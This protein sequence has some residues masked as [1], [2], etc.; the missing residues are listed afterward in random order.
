ML[1]RQRRARARVVGWVA[2]PAA[3]LS[4]SG[5]RAAGA[6]S[7]ARARARAAGQ[8]EQLRQHRHLLLVR[9]PLPV[10]QQPQRRPRP[11]VW[12]CGAGEAGSSSR[13]GFGSPL[14]LGAS[15]LSA[16]SLSASSASTPPACSRWQCVAAAACQRAAAAAHSR[17]GESCALMAVILCEV[18]TW[19]LDPVL[20]LVLRWEVDR[21]PSGQGG[22][23]SLAFESPSRQRASARSDIPATSQRHP[24]EISES[25]SRGAL[26]GA[27]FLRALF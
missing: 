1:Q 20:S 7:P 10:S 18:D 23:V 2:A 6:W 5:C 3:A 13:G 15:S 11:S 4:R 19:L 17:G 14:S 12:R 24:S 21:C 22:G 8:S 9:H 16:S 27:P 25:L 26:G